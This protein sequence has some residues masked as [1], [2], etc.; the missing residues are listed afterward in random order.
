[1]IGG[2]KQALGKL[3]FPGFQRILDFTVP[4]PDAYTKLLLHC[5]GANGGTTIYDECGK[6]ATLV[7]TAQ[8]STAQKV[9][10][11]SSLLL[12]GNSDYVTFADSDD[13]TFG[14]GDFT[15]D[16][17]F[18]ATSFAGGWNQILGQIDNVGSNFWFVGIANGGTSINMTGAGDSA[19]NIGANYAFS[20]GTWYHIAIVRNG[21]DKDHWHFFVN[22]Q[23]QATSATSYNPNFGNNANAL[24]IGNAWGYYWDGYLDELRISKGIARWTADFTPPTSEYTDSYAT[25]NLAVDG[26]TDK[27]YLINARN[28]SARSILLNINYQAVNLFGRQYIYNSAGTIGATRD[29]ANLTICTTLSASR[30]VV[31]TPASL[32]KTIL[33]EFARFTTGTTIEQYFVSGGA[34]KSTDAV[35]ALNFSL[36]STGIFTAGTR[37]TVYARRSQS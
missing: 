20:T 17:W 25:Y 30:S 37:I 27:E 13:W 23:E 22:G 6:A 36:H 8:T 33:V 9:F 35:G 7:G 34:W 18:R 16:F 4:T 24:R 1:M 19:V 15:I 2:K 26:D 29:T 5:N 14:T 32:Q 28:L 21:N 12:D 11:N 3:N 31:K 10:G